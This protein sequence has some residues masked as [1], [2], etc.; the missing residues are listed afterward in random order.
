MNE[1]WNTMPFTTAMLAP[2]KAPE[3]VSDADLNSLLRGRKFGKRDEDLPLNMNPE[4]PVYDEAEM[5][6]LQEFCRQRGIIGVNFNGMNPRAVLKML[7]R[8]MGMTEQTTKRGLI[9]G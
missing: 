6:E 2:H 4:I 7:K 9:N 8:K 3:P 1:S 5:Q